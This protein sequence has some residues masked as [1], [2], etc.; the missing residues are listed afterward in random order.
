MKD[1]PAQP[2]Q[3][4]PNAAYTSEDWFRREQRQL[5]RKSWTF[6]AMADDLSPGDYL[7]T[8]VGGQPVILLRDREGELRAFHNVCRHR[9]SR[10][11][12]GRGKLN[13]AITCFYH[14][15]SYD[16]TG[17]LA[18]VPQEKKRF[19]EIDK[20]CLG[21]VPVGVG[22]WRGLVFLNPDPG[23]ESLSAWLGGLDSRCGPHRP[24]E[25]VEIADVR[26]RHRANWK[27]LIENFM[28]GY[29]L[30]PLH[31]RSLPDGDFSTLRFVSE[32]RHWTNTRD[33]KEG[34]VSGN[35]L[36]PKILG[37][38]PDFGANYHLIFPNLCVFETATTWMTFHAI[39]ISPGVADAHVRIR[40]HRDALKAKVQ[41]PVDES[42]PLHPAI[43]HAKGP[44]AGMRVNLP[45]VHP[46]ES[47]S[48][49]MEDIYACEAMQQ[50]LESDVSEIGAMCDLEAPIAFFQQRLL[51]RMS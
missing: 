4:L 21:L 13:R 6:A 50:G 35:E 34:W 40:A 14:G 22:E 31:G 2:R 17:A 19:Q 43:L 23:A 42:R 37:V 48:V 44:Y 51:D 36:L 7:T 49:M 3:L 33:A 20:S 30:V 15:W 47:L 16:L 12:E 9:L 1:A 27:V 28:D 5:F 32:G 11:L 18:A 38:P 25:L 41:A 46:L 29:H 45:D 8:E 10:L 26:Y 39:P 24:E